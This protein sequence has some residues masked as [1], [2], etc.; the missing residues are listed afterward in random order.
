MPDG[1]AVEPQQSDPESEDPFE[2]IPGPHLGPIPLTPQEEE[3]WQVIRFLRLDTLVV[4]R[5][6]DRPQTDG[7]L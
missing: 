7:A 1:E 5:G 4:V 3:C 6:P 2:G